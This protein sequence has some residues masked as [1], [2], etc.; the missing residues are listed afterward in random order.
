MMIPER[1]REKCGDDGE[2]EEEAK[3]GVHFPNK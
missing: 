3:M 1:E 2:E